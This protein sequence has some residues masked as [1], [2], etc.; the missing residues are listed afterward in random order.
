MN[1]NMCVVVWLGLV[2][3]GGGGVVGGRRRLVY[4]GI[5]STPPC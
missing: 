4:T 3:S 1:T 5:C 2:T